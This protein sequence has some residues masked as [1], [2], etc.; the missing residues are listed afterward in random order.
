[1]REARPT[2]R[3]CTNAD[4][5][6]RPEAVKASSPTNMLPGKTELHGSSPPNIGGCLDHVAIA[7]DTFS[8]LVPLLEHLSGERATPPERVPSQGVDVCFVGSM[9]LIRALDA[10]NSVGRFVERRGAALHHVAY[11]VRDLE[12]T[13]EE[14]L[15]Q[16][17]TFTAPGPTQGARGHRV[18]FL[19]PVSTGGVLIELLE[20]APGA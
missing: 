15:S 2:T 18:A 13:M 1:M 19:R 8:H 7:V 17:R 14:L 3:P 12:A 9:E 11:R 6:T 16:G 5:L 10:T 20:R 4:P